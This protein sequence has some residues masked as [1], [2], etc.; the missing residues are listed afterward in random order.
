MN[1]TRR[2]MGGCSAENAECANLIS[3]ILDFKGE[4]SITTLKKS[5]ICRN[6]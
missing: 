2:E 1:G 6:Y 4:F 5:K 3:Q